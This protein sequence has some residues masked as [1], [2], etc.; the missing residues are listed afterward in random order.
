MHRIFF[1]P[2]LV[3]CIVEKAAIHA[4]HYQDRSSQLTRLSTAAYRDVTS[5]GLT[6][7]IFREPSL[8]AI[9]TIQIAFL[10]LLRCIGAVT[11]HMSLDE[12]G[13]VVTTY[14]CYLSLLATS[15]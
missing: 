4:R 13:K 2:E 7:R 3:E 12:D 14:V 9:W 15:P 8:D 10:P 5:L 11:E 1:I 6:S